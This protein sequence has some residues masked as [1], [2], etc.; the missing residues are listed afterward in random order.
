MK[1]KG[2]QAV[3]YTKSADGD[4]WLPL[5]EQAKRIKVTKVT[6][7]LFHSQK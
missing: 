3:D 7:T 4:R 2:F 6:K 1:S 5:T